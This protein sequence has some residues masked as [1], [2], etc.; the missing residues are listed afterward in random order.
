MPQGFTLFGTVLDPTTFPTVQI[1]ASNVIHGLKRRSHCNHQVPK[2]RGSNSEVVGVCTSGR[3]QEVQIVWISRNNSCSHLKI[4][5]NSIAKRKPLA[6]QPC[7]T[8][9]AIR[10][11]P[12]GAPANSTC[13]M[14]SRY[15]LRRERPIKS[16]SSVFSITE[17]IHECLTLD[18]L[19]QNLSTVRLIPV[20]LTQHVPD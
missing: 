18:T 8:P 9:L 5:S 10:N 7:R 6:G 16:G 13:V 3:L 15:T 4:G 1:E 14:L 17:R 11:C 20:E 12:R 19:Q 2:I